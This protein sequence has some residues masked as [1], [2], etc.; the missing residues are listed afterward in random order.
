MLKIVHL[1]DTHL[2]YL[3]QGIQRLVE[4]PWQP[5][6]QIRQQE[7]DLMHGLVEA[8]D[9][10]LEN[11]KPH[12]VVHSGDLFDGARPTARMLNFAM[13]QIGRLS[14]DGIP[15]VLIEG[16]HSFPRDR[17]QGHVLHLFSHLSGVRVVCEEP[18]IIRV[19]DIIV[20]AY[21][22]R[23][24]ALGRRPAHRDIQDSSFRMLLAHGVADGHEFFKTGRPASDLPVEG[25]A[26][27]YDYVGL[28]HCHRF[29][30]VP[31]TGC[32]FYA[33]STGMVSWGDF[34]PN[35]TF[36]FNVVSL[37]DSGLVVKRELIETRLMHAYGLDNA[38]GLTSK[39][40]LTLLALQAKAVSPSEAYCRVVV[41]NMDP[42]AR[43]EL[44]S[45][46]VEEIFAGAASLLV[47]LRARQQHWDA[48]RA[49]LA[50]GG[51]PEARFAQLVA[52]TD[53][54]Q[55]FREEVLK[56][57]QDLLCRAYEKIGAEDTSV[58]GDDEAGG[59]A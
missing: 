8:V 37:D 30:Q 21:P 51:T 27:W 46:Q 57:G 50:E 1:S 28:G 40:V 26:D 7:L 54:D 42:L 24:L 38:E 11:V 55:T 22:H 45:R 44:S 16:N 35:H 53:G 43:R 39:E 59:N 15:V 48:V 36:G 10:I 29:A 5:G 18:D 33:G 12:L 4:D 32:A 56:L 6:A 3:G 58:E 14:M 41:E 31:G 25:C 34:R 49:D 20:H 13:T 2:G 23:A 17:S 19:G 47:S 9:L 52:Q